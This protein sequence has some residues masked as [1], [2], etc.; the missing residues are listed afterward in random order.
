MTRRYIRID[1]T[2]PFELTEELR[3]L[4]A[5]SGCVASVWHTQD[6]RSLRP[7]LSDGQSMEVLNQCM[8][9]HDASIGINWDVIQCHADDLFPEPDAGA[10]LT[11]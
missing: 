1:T 6:V 7:D 5:K 4:L 3:E 8:R 2:K 9:R 10:T 11:E